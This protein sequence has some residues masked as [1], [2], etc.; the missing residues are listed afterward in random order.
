VPACARAGNVIGTVSAP[1]PDKIVVFVEGVKGTFPAKNEVIDQKGKAFIPYVLPVLKGAT[2][3]FRNQDAMAHNVMG[4]G[5]DEFNLG[6]FGKGGARDHTFN[7][8][9]TTAAN[10]LHLLQ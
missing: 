4:V 9:R 1:H 6:A 8:V 7:K 10:R 3:S 5:G 2:I